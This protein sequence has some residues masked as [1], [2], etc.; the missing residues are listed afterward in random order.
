MYFT[1]LGITFLATLTGD[2]ASLRPVSMAVPHRAPFGVNPE[3]LQLR[4]DKG[5]SYYL[6]MA[7]KTIQNMK[8]MGQEIKQDQ[9]QV[10]VWHVQP[11]GNTPDGSCLVYMRLAAARIVMDVGGNKIEYDSDANAGGN[12]LGDLFNA[13]LRTEFK[14]SMRVDGSIQRVEGREEFLKR[15]DGVGGG[16]K[17]LLQ[18]ILN[19]DAILQM[20]NPIGDFLP[21]RAVVPGESWRRKRTLEL[22]PIGRYDTE[23]TYRLERMRESLADMSFTSTFKYRV[24]EAKKPEALPFVIKSAE[25]SKGIGNGK[26]V[27]DAQRGRIHE[28]LHE[29]SLS[30]TL[31]IDIAQM[32][33]RIELDQVQTS[34]VRTFDAMPRRVR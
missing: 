26:V 17:A 16:Q 10:L 6:E 32:E 14:L 30:A 8:V 13:M 20:M 29:Q 7:T 23:S 3:L 19:E 33:S 28:I 4:L 25:T 22:G 5:Q 24:A 31:V 15:L 21:E 2:S 34:R 9:D 1:I 27:F 11:Q 12:P 18:A